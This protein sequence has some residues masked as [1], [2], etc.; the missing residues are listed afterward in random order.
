MTRVR[1]LFWRLTGKSRANAGTYRGW[2]AQ[3]VF[4]EFE[5]DGQFH[6]NTKTKDW[7][8][9]FERGYGRVSKNKDQSFRWTYRGDAH[10][11]FHEGDQP[12]WEEAC[13]M[14]A[15]YARMYRYL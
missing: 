11:A 13:M 8:A 6:H 1:Y 10:S 9:H 2:Y 7:D 15:K 4:P 14:S 5:R 12:T 3:E